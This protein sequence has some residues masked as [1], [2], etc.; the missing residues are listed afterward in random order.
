MILYSDEPLTE[1]HPVAAHLLGSGKAR[2][3]SLCT[4]SF[5]SLERQYPFVAT[6]SVASKGARTYPSTIIAKHLYLGDWE[7]ACNK[8]ALK[9]GGCPVYKSNPL[10]LNVKRLV[11]RHDP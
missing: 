3:V 4:D 11:W 5:A 9:V 1:S 10:T 6:T 7:H 2:S 8:E